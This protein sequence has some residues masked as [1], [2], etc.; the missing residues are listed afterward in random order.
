MTEMPIEQGDKQTHAVLWD[1]LN[2]AVNMVALRNGQSGISTAVGMLYALRLMLL[3]IDEKATRELLRALA[4]LEHGNEADEEKLRK[5][6]HRIYRAADALA[7]RDGAV[8]Q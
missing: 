2:M 4:A 6:S 7:E 3:E 8:M 1:T 5:I